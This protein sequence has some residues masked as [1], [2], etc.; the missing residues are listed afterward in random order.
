MEK[1]ETLF[2]ISH[3]EHLMFLIEMFIDKSSIV[4]MNF[5]QIDELETC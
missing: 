3:L 2:L 5:V 4:Y 1:E